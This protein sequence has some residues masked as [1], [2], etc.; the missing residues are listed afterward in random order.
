MERLNGLVERITFVNEENGFSVI[1]LRCKGYHELVTAVG[2]MA[3]VNIGA[4]VSL[5]GEWITD[6]KYGRQFK[7]Q[8]YQE[9]IPAT[10][11]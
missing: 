11:A 2:T 7:V 6:S 10:V 4:V 9:R 5:Q 1:K 3:A 8:F